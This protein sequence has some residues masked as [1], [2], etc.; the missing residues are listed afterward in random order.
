MKNVLGAAVILWSLAAGA[1]AQAPLDSAKPGEGEAELD[2]RIA[3]Y[4]EDERVKKDLRYMSE[5][6]DRETLEDEEAEKS[7]QAYSEGGLARLAGL[8][9]RGNLDP[10]LRPVLDRLETLY[11]ELAGKDYAKDFAGSLVKAVDE[12]L[13]SAADSGA[14]AA[15]M[16]AAL[17][18]GLELPA[19]IPGDGDVEDQAFFPT[20]LTVDQFLKLGPIKIFLAKHRLKR[21]SSTARAAAA[22]L[23]AG[24]HHVQ[25]GVEVE[26]T[27]TWA[28]K[29]PIDQ[30]YCFNIGE[31][32]MEI[33]PEWRLT[34]PGFVTPKVGQK[35][36]VKGWTYYDYFHK[37]ELEYDPADP[38]L[39]T[40][41][42]VV[43]EIHPVQDV[44][45]IR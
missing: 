37:S 4:Q 2:R 38:V 45:V 20:D 22:D 17:E 6:L 33:T 5:E 32:H 26:G 1:A 10:M 23:I 42:K 12:E 8:R 25:V 44:K 40:L 36:R 14:D 34:H 13:R 31:L 35:V 19:A 30:D 27:V 21:P 39:G 3:A 28:R 24:K 18:R 41:R 16:V 11:R 15:G 43:W 9:A 29:F 7:L